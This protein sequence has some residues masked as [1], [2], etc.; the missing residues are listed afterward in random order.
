[1][2]SLAPSGFSQRC[3]CSSPRSL[4]TLAHIPFWLGFCRGLTIE[5]CPYIE[6]VAEKWQWVSKKV[7]E[8]RNSSNTGLTGAQPGWLKRRLEPSRGAFLEVLG[9]SG[10]RE[11]RS[12]LLERVALLVGQAQIFIGQAGAERWQRAHLR[13]VGWRGGRPRGALEQQMQVRTVAQTSEAGQ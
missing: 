8:L 2:P 7:T 13:R 5:G 12:A 4:Q 3:L 11:R 10:V 9:D 1:M 6:G